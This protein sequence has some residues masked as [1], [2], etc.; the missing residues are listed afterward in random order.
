[1]Q[2]ITE[3]GGCILVGAA[4]NGLAWLFKAGACHDGARHASAR[5]PLAGAHTPRHARANLP[6]PGDSC[7]LNVTRIPSLHDVIYYGL[8]PPIIFEAGFTMRKHGFFEN[9]G[10]ILLYAVSPPSHESTT[11]N[12]PPSRAPL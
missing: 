10:T 2:A 9:F 8:L 6:P 11:A 7:T 1:M 5:P 3:T 12:R 4:F